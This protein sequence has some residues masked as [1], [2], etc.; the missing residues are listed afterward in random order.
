MKSF[1]N[2]I[3]RENC[4]TIIYDTDIYRAVV[5]IFIDRVALAKQGNNALG[6]VHL[7][8]RPYVCLCWCTLGAR[9]CRVQQIAI[10]VITSLMY[11]CLCVCNQGAYTGNSAGAVDRLLILGTLKKKRLTEIHTNNNPSHHRKIRIT[12]SFT[13]I[14]SRIQA[15]KLRSYDEGIFTNKSEVWPI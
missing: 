4:K 13:D 8:V 12:W 1:D 7:S 3:W 15:F 10:R 11:L 6:S 9:L 2:S 14:V 5:R